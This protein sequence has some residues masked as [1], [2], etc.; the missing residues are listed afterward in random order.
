M[1]PSLSTLRRAVE[2][3]GGTLEEDTGYRDMRCLQLVAPSGQWWAGAGVQCYRLDWARGHSP[4]AE[5]GNAEALRDGL[6][7][8]AGGLAPIPASM[9]ELYAAD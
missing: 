4:Q 7:I 3:A 8:C 6:A 1:K 5:R 9:A 2:A